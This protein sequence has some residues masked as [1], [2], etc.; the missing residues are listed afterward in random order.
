MDAEHFDRIARALSTTPSRRGS[1]RL[2]AGAALGG[3]L[4]LPRGAAAQVWSESNAGSCRAPGDICDGDADCCSE[5]CRSGRCLCRR[6]GAACEV[7]RACCSDRCR[8][9]TGRCA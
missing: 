9:R 6:R 1:L 3:L 7:D 4:A 2:L 8:Q 5:R